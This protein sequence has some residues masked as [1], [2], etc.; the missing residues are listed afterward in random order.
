M[1]A[2]P[3]VGLPEVEWMEVFNRTDRIMNLNGWGLVSE[4]S[5]VEPGIVRTIL[6]KNNWNGYLPPYA[7]CLLCAALLRPLIAF[8][9]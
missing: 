3:S 5:T 1:D 6:P 8:L 4:S 2:T 9:K 7:R